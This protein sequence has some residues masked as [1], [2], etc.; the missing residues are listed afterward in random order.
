MVASFKETVLTM[1]DFNSFI[2][3]KKGLLFAIC[4][5][6]YFRAANKDV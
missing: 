3:I 2:E 4:F 5:F 1:P 6:A